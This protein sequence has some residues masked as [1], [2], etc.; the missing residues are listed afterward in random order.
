LIRAMQVESS[1]R[2]GAHAAPDIRNLLAAGSS[3][4]LDCCTVAQAI[5]AAGPDDP[6]P[7]PLLFQTP[8]LNT[9]VLIKA[10]PPDHR[11]VD[12]RGQPR[13]RVGTKIYVPFDGRR[14][15]DGG[16]TTFFGTKQFQAA[17]SG[18]ID[19]EQPAKRAAFESDCAKLVMLDKLPSLAP[20]L[21]R[22]R[23]EL[24]KIDVDRR[25]FQLPEDEWRQIC[26]FIRAEFARIIDAILPEQRKASR[27]KFDRLLDRLWTLSDVQGLEELADAFSIPRSECLDTFYA[28]KGVIYFKFEFA[29]SWSA[30]QPCFE[31]LKA[32]AELPQIADPRTRQ[33]L[34]VVLRDVYGRLAT[35]VK[36]VRERLKTYEAGFEALFGEKGD[37]RPFLGFLKEAQEQF[38]VI[39]LSLAR[40]QHMVEVWSTRSGG[41]PNRRMPGGAIR[42]LLAALVDLSRDEN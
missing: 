28:W 20:F 29:R 7:G 16:Q 4:V 27:E 31:W 8:A 5:A 14:L 12:S 1:T 2:A 24:A 25:Y 35:A 33:G 32:N 42:D 6:P 39:G 38:T 30:M 22:D 34:Q 26:S 37:P 13:T 10:L 23:L 21:L 11:F 40:A 15:A 3:R 18:L 9:A 17:M 19:L 41:Y 36:D